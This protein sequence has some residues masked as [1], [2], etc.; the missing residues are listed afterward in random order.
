MACCLTLPVCA[1]FVSVAVVCRLRVADVHLLIG[2]RGRPVRLGASRVCEP[3]SH[4]WL[5]V[6]CVMCVYAAAVGVATLYL[7]VLL[8]ENPYVHA[9][10]DRC[11]IS[12]SSS[13][14]RRSFATDHALV[15]VAARLSAAVGRALLPLMLLACGWSAQAALVGAVGNLLAALRR[16]HQGVYER[17]R[18]GER[19]STKLSSVARSCCS[20]LLRP[21]C[22]CSHRPSAGSFGLVRAQ[23]LCCGTQVQTGALSL[24]LSVVLVA[25]AR[26][27]GRRC[28]Q[29]MTAVHP[30]GD[31]SVVG[32]GTGNSNGKPVALMR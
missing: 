26:Q 31:S 10:D 21:A 24:M 28:C 1:W 14:L 23:A 17:P 15:L 25:F 9:D 4:C 8:V 30:R 16:A 27:V 7:V 20:V 12:L 19:F 29:R 22:C 32:G 3:T 5:F 13:P 6:A 11:E 2:P 18:L